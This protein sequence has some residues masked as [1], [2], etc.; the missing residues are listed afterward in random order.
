M[1]TALVKT[2]IKCH[3]IDCNILNN[4]RPVSDITLLS[5]IIER[6]VAFILNKYLFNTNLK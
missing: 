5:I 4:Y 1:N 3:T 6:A 2:L